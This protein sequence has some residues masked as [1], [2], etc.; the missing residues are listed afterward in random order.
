MQKLVGGHTHDVALERGDAVERPTVGVAGDQLVDLP[1]VAGGSVDQ[2]AREGRGVPVELLRG[3]AAGDL[4]L[5]EGE[6]G[7]AALIG[8]SH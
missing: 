7:G 6:H 3:L 2:L 4:R 1:A 5:V 8:A